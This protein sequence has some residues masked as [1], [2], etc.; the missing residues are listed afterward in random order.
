MN[1]NVCYF[2]KPG[3]VNTDETLQCARRRAEELGIGHVLVAT[4]RGDTAL[5]AADLFQGTNV[6][7]LAIPH[8]YGWKKPGEWLITPEVQ[9][10][11]EGKGVTVATSTMVFSMPGRPF[12]P[13]AVWKPPAGE[14]FYG[15]G[16]PLDVVAD[17]LRLF[18]QGMKVCV[19]I[20]IMAA[21]MGLI[22]VDGEV[23]SI[24][25]TGRGADTAVVIKPAH[26]PTLLELRIREVL[27][28]PR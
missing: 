10:E 28:M 22:P 26:L 18:S 25:G 4:T 20:V 5:R 24:A 16:F 11:L 13:Q 17:T 1:L 6:K 3:P 9:R 7:L 8:Q 19:E 21:D 15:S 27:A 14:S 2:E 12:R 23:I